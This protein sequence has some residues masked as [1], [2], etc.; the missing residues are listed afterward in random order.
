MANMGSKHP[1]LNIELIYYVEKFWR[2]LSTIK[3]YSLDYSL[4]HFKSGPELCMEVSWMRTGSEPEVNRKWTSVVV[5]FPYFEPFLRSDVCLSNS[6]MKFKWKIAIFLTRES[7]YLYINGTF[8][9]Y[10][11]YRP[12]IE[13]NEQTIYPWLT[14]QECLLH[15]S[16]LSMGGHTT[17]LVDR[18]RMMM[19]LLE[20]IRITS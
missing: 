3:Y 7:S 9:F 18:E 15:V 20:R 14:S 10:L 16:F 19:M 5:D 12:S 4:K 2:I 13:M 1:L 17:Q 8:T 6:F 11:L